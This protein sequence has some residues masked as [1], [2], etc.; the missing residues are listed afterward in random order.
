MTF[1]RAIEH[2]TQQK[3]GHDIPQKRFD[4]MKGMSL[5]G[6]QHGSSYIRAKHIIERWTPIFA[7]HG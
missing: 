2:F 1:H 5:T 6:K 3:Y 4:E 7:K